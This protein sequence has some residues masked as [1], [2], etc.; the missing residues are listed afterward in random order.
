MPTLLDVAHFFDQVAKRIKAD[1][2]LRLVNS[3]GSGMRGCQWN[4]YTNH[5]WLLDTVDEQNKALSLVYSGNAVDVLNIHYYTN[6][7]CRGDVVKGPDGQD[8]PMDLVKYVAAARAI[9]K[10][11]MVGEAGVSA[12]AKNSADPK[13][14]KVY[15][16]TP[17]YIDSYWDPNAAK[18]VKILCDQIVDAGPQLVYWWEYGSNRPVDQHVPSFDVKK[19]RTDAVLNLIV[20]ANKRLKAKLGAM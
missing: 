13:D 6:N 10:P 7:H 14:R 9:G 2:P 20:D 3:G 8:V 17:D 11:L 5:K 15:A 18:W 4:Q 1:D 16:E 19:G 12:V